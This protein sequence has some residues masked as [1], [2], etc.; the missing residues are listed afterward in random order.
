MEG[1]ALFT[2]EVRD[3]QDGYA[4]VVLSGELD[5]N[6]TTTLLD[7]VQPQAASGRAVVLDMHAVTFCDS[8]GLNSLVKL[9]KAARAAGGSLRLA[10]VSDTV[11]RVVTIVALDRILEIVDEVP[12]V[13]GD[14]R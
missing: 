14:P 2:A 13:D 1:P 3:A 4:L 10:R 8:G 11:R 9:H 12:S 6:T 5:Y 7:V